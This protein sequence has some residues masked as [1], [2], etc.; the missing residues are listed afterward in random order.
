MRTFTGFE[1]RGMIDLYQQGATLN[2]LSDTFEVSVPVIRRALIDN[3]VE[4]RGVGRLTSEKATRAKSTAFMQRVI[5]AL[6]RERN[7]AKVSLWTV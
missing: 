4:I 6:R 2:Q 5:K 7:K 1:L 3:S